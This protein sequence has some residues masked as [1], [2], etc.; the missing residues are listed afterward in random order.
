MTDPFNRWFQLNKC[1]ARWLES[2]PIDRVARCDRQF[3]HVVQP[4]EPRLQINDGRG[5]KRV[6]ARRVNLSPSYLCV[7]CAASEF[8]LRPPTNPNQ[9][10][11]W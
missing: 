3:R 1:D 7:S 8:G 5:P 10:E 2:S 11:L 9:G 4:Y 6:R